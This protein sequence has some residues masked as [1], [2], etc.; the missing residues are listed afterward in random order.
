MITQSLAMC[1]RMSDE[2]RRPD[3]SV[4]SFDTDSERKK[5]DYVITSIN[6]IRSSVRRKA[7]RGKTDR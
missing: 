1:T 4:G 3:Y 5:T 6:S 2:Q 7:Q